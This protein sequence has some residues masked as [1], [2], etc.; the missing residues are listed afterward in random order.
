MNKKYSGINTRIKVLH[1]NKLYHP[2]IGGVEK[3]VQDLCENLLPYDDISIQVLVC[4]EKMASEDTI[5][6]GVRVKKLANLVNFFTKKTLLFSSPVSLTLP[7]WIRKLSA[8]ILHFHLPN[9]LAMAVYYITRPKGKVV[10][11]WHSDIVKQ[12]KMLYFLT[13]LIHWFLNRTDTIITTSPNIIDSSPFLSE[14]RQKCVV[15]PLGINPEKYV[16]KDEDYAQIKQERAKATMPLILFVG[17]LVYYKGVEYLVEAMKQVDAQLIIVGEGPLYTTVHE[18][19]ISNGLSNKISIVPSASDYTLVKYFH[20]CDIFVLPSVSQSEAFGIVQLEAMKCSKP[21][22][23]TNLPT[24]VPFVNQ[25]GKTGIIVEPKDID[26]LAKAINTLIHDPEL[27]NSYGLYAKQ[28]IEEE[29]TNEVMAKKVYNLYN[30][31]MGRM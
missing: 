8:D 22:I 2:W 29:F 28:R 1:I 31:I 15:I 12:K 5:I 20:S 17:R 30:T 4:H 21:V 14:F 6:N 3:H 26:G 13:P 23:S 24:G 25:H 9:P 7:F 16:L 19:I 10:V 11:T 27:R 18:K